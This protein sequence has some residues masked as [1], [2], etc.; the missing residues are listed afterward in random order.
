MCFTQSTRFQAHCWFAQ[1]MLGSSQFCFSFQPSSPLSLL[2]TP[3]FL[4]AQDPSSQVGTQSNFAHPSYGVGVVMYP[5]GCSS[6][7]RKGYL[8]AKNC[9]SFQA[10]LTS[11]ALAVPGSCSCSAQAEEREGSRAELLLWLL[12][13]LREPTPSFALFLSFGILSLH[14][15]VF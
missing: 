4:F 13:W 8:V 2:S 14:K 7:K 12:L 9:C 15:S 1:E 3:G 11:S 10:H 6:F 5:S